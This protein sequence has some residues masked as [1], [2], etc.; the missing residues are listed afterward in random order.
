MEE[1]KERND[2]IVDIFDMLKP[3]L[4]KELWSHVEKN[5]PRENVNWGKSNLE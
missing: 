4:D 2:L 1:K 3:W 5:K